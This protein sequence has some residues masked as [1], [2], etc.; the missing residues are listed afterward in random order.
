VLAA[1]NAAAA[2]FVVTGWI[3]LWRSTPTLRT[4]G[5]ADQ[6]EGVA[7]LARWRVSGG[8]DRSPD[9]ADGGVAS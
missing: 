8:E 5:S 2:L 7:E 6:R 4:A 1:I 9:R 3:V